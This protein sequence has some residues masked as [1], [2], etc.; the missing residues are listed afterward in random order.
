M[1]TVIH[2]MLFW[3]RHLIHSC[4]LKYI[5]SILALWWFH[6]SDTWCSIIPWYGDIVNHLFI[7][8]LLRYYISLLMLSCS[9]L[10]YHYS[11]EVDMYSVTIHVTHCI[12]LFVT[13]MSIVLMTVDDTSLKY[14][15]CCCY[16]YCIMSF[17]ILM[18]LLMK[19][20][21]SLHW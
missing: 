21:S 20:C 16:C 10:F 5:P 2:V 1:L 6:Y 7:V 12:I 19:H 3:Y 9:I 15:F 8:L 14:L 4:I 17:Y 13:V 11:D 18:T